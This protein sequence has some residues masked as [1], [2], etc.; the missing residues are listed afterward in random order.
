[1][2]KLKPKEQ[3]VYDY[4]TKSVQENGYAPSVRDICNDLGYKSTSTVQIY[5]NRLALFGYISKEDGKSRTMYPTSNIPKARL[6]PVYGE[7]CE[8]NTNLEDLSPEDY[9][10]F[11]SDHPTISLFGFRIYGDDLIN[12]GIFDGD[13][14]IAQK[15]CYAEN[16][17]IVIAII[18]GKAKAIR[19][20]R[21]NGYY[22]LQ[23]ENNNSQEI[24]LDEVL[25]L[26]HVIS[27]QRKLDN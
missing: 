11:V 26:G 15:T 12:I 13:I 16:G 3:K 8:N 24:I 20:F 14:A 2:E 4:I 5:L 23:K 22:R 17:Q 18:E 6:I 1:M 10:G 21:E 9:V 19:F 25:I 27:I 7:I